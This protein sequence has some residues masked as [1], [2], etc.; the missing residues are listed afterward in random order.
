MVLHAGT[1]QSYIE[2]LKKRQGP[3]ADQPHRVVYA[4]LVRRR[5]GAVR[6]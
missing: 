1:Y 3:D 4:K 6:L 2:D 5:A